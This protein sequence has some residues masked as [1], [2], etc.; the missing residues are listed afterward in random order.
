MITFAVPFVLGIVGTLLIEWRFR[1]Q[2]SENGAHRSG[3]RTSCGSCSSCSRFACPAY[4]GAE[5]LPRDGEASRGL[6][7][8][9]GTE[10][11]AA[12]CPALCRDGSGGRPA[13][14][15]AWE[16]VAQTVAVL[17]RRVA[18]FHRPDAWTTQEASARFTRCCMRPK[19][20]ISGWGRCHRVITSRRRR[21]GG[22][23]CRGGWN[24]CSGRVV[25][26]GRPGGRAFDQRTSLPTSPSALRG[27]E[28]ARTLRRSPRRARQ[29]EPVTVN[30]YV[31]SPSW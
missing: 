19:C 10:P 18:R 28:T 4:P 24:P 31:Q 6:R 22:S 20:S 29:N 5:S 21:N 27:R 8:G 26:T 23:N 30:S 15:E 2:S 9:R 3:G 17:S 11:A 7:G 14:Y 25:R 16:E 1:P 13:A 12:R